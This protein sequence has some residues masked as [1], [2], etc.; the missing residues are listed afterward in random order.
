VSNGLV[1][2]E[3]S[4]RMLIKYSSAMFGA[5]AAY[6]MF[7][8]SAVRAQDD[9]WAGAPDP[10]KVAEQAK[11]IQT[12]GIPDAWANYG[13]VFQAFWTSLGVT[14]GTHTDSDMSSMEEITKFDA[15]KDNPVAQFADIGL[16]FGQIAERRGVV[17]PY[18]PPSAEKLPA[19][20][21]AETGGWV[22]TFAGVPAFVINSDAFAAA[23]IAEPAT[24][25]DLLKPEMKGKVGSP[26]DPRSSGTAATTFL[27]WSYAHGG[28]AA[29]LEP[30]IEYAKQLLPQYSSAPGSNDLLEKQEHLLWIRYDFN[31]NASVN[32]LKEKGINARTVIPGVSIYA[33]SAIMANKYNTA[34]ADLIK[35]FLEYVLS[36]EAQTIFARFGARPIR[37]VLGDMTLPEEAKANW[38][39][40][41]NYKDVVVVE[42][43]VE[44]DADEITTVWDDEV[45]GG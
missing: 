45:L 34:D 17:P 35:A 31:C 24:W 40:E 23:G 29:N 19:G 21:K 7:G 28:D 15:E 18:L 5:A 9:V 16:L 3:I 12:Y 44:I 10:A 30:A 2:A 13:E 22:A 25:D 32:I 41:E 4:R 1:S 14:D 38:L 36:D 27:A 37:S 6:R 26:G 33:P 42:N 20:Y 8:G 43:F 11:D 39:P